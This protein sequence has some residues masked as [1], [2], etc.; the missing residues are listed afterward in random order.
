MDFSLLPDQPADGETMLSLSDAV[1]YLNTFRPNLYRLIST[2]QLT[3][4]RMLGR[5]RALYL[6]KAD[7]DAI[8]QRPA[9]PRAAL[10]T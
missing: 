3:A 5:S 6:R 10:P 4:Y 7:L 8:R 1:R 9:P 2:R